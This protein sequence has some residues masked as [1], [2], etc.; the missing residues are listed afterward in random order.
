MR[1]KI[2]TK[3]KIYYDYNVQ[4]PFKYKR[5]APLKVRR[6]LIRPNGSQIGTR[7]N[8]D[9]VWKKRT[10]GKHLLPK[11]GRNSSPDINKF[12]QR[13]KEK[14]NTAHQ[15]DSRHSS[16]ALSHKACYAFVRAI[17]LT[18]CRRKNTP[19]TSHNRPYK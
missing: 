9:R 18:S 14:T 6:G 12:F 4:L 3:E 10:S 16:G 5:H 13:A 8:R 2:Y 11:K 1:P 17:A 19:P 15:I 7:K